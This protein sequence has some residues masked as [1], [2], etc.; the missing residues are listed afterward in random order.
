VEAKYGLGRKHFTII[1]KAGYVPTS[2]LN[3]HEGNEPVP[4][5]GH[6]HTQTHQC[7]SKQPDILK[8]RLESTHDLLDLS[9]IG[10][11]DTYHSLHPSL[12]QQQLEHSLDALQTEYLDVY[13]LH[14]PE[15][16]I[17][18]QQMLERVG[19]ARDRLVSPP[20]TSSS[21]PQAPP[22]LPPILPALSSFPSFEEKLFEAFVVL[23]EAVKE[24]K[25]KS[26]GISSNW[27]AYAS[28]SSQLGYKAWTDIAENAYRH[29]NPGSSS[30]DGRKSSFRCIQFPANLLETYG[31]ERVAP[32]AKAQGLDV[33]VNRPLD[34]IDSV[35]QWRLASYKG[36]PNSQYNVLLERTLEKFQSPPG[37]DPNSSLAKNNKFMTAVITDLDRE[38][39]KFS[40]VYHYQQDFSAQIMPMLVERMS[41]MQDTE[42]LEAIQVFLEVYESKVREHCSLAAEEKIASLYRGK[43]STH[44]TL[45]QFAMRYLLDNPNIDCVLN[46]MTRS[47]YVDQAL[48]ELGLSAGQL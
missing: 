5:I 17:Q 45:Q 7:A 34:A 18:Y 48:K 25:L 24:G 13:L 20:A 4:P 38:R 28:E 22:D 32:W 43:Y 10:I 1:S 40:S 44:T 27:L 16:Y 47:T 36:I 6:V 19:P 42:V 31:A 41:M 29:I 2:D 23:E 21:P 15:H 14:N 8:A 46:G 12:I 26:Y 11:G 39:F 37:T 30:K 33:I 9:H 3:V 35:G